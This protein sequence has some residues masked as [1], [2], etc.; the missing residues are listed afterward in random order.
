LREHLYTCLM[1]PGEVRRK[2]REA[3]AAVRKFVKESLLSDQADVLMPEAEAAIAALRE[4]MQ[5]HD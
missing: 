1:L 3:R 5:R 2:A 4:T